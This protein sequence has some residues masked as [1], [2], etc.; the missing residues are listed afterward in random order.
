MTL[1]IQF[2]SR[3]VAESLDGEPKTGMISI[4]SPS[5]TGP[6][7]S[8]GVPAKI[9]PGWGALLRLE[10]DDITPSIK[11]KFGHYTL[12]TE[13]Q[14]R[15][16]LDWLEVNLPNLDTIYVHCEAGISR[17]AAVAKFI[18]ET[19]SLPFSFSEVRFANDHV[20]R[21]L[22][23]E[24]ILRKERKRY[25]DDKGSLF[26]LVGHGFNSKAAEIVVL[27]TIRGLLKPGT[28]VTALAWTFY[29]PYPGF[30]GTPYTEVTDE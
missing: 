29:D 25:R 20:H 7:R 8:P 15:E 3:E 6:N 27:R 19:Y 1:N 17:S 21:L 23:Q 4:S 14:A 30:E 12:M 10:F 28:F 16:I 2:F 24:W 9:C 11:H 26:E 22:T 5:D 13:E 18:G